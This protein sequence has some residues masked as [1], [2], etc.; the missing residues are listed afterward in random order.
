[1]SQAFPLVEHGSSVPTL[2]TIRPQT[3]ITLSKSKRGVPTFFPACY[4]HP[5]VCE[6]VCVRDW[7]YPVIDD[8]IVIKRRTLY[9]VRMRR[10]GTLAIIGTT[11]THHPMADFQ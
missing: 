9:S 10:F 4:V 5:C 8:L 11:P 6:C 3:M 7:P 2:R 1:V